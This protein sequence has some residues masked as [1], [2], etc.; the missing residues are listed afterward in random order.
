MTRWIALIGIILCGIAAVF[1]GERR[2]VDV[3][4]SPAALLYFVGDTERELTRMP[5]RLT[6]M[7]DED[8]IRIGDELARE[9][10]ERSQL[11]SEDIREER[12]VQEVGE[13]VAAHA[14]RRLPFGRWTSSLLS[15]RCPIPAQP[16]RRIPRALVDAR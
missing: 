10:Q 2:K 8:E 7:P 12:Y 9:Y 11:D 14:H 6:R 15:R 13:R 4:A 3:P 1:V 5:M 16:R